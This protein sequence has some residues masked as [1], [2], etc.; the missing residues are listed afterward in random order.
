MMLAGKSLISKHVYFFVIDKF[1]N[2]ISVVWWKTSDGN[3]REK[4][5]AQV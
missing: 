4:S 2:E 5:D 3:Q 1:F